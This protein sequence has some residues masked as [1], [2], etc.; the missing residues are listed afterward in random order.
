MKIRLEH[1][2][3][4]AA[5]MQIAE[6]S[7]FTAINALELKGRNVSNSFLINSQVA[8]VCKYASEP[9]GNGEY[10]FTF[11]KEQLDNLELL[12]P[13]HDQLYFGL[14]CVR[15]TEICCL[16]KEEFLKLQV[17][18]RNSSKV[19]ESA[20]V[21]LVSIEAGKSF[22]AYVNAAGKRGQYAGKQLTITRKSFP[23]SIFT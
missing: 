6:H 5:V 16:S 4:G 2:N 10:A 19:K 20:L 14:V 12:F 15:D 18:R 7:Q 17:F 13:K 8:V 3:I 21:V 11:T 22:R 23:D 9:N 1:Q